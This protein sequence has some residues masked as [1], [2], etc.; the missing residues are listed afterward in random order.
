MT[1]ITDKLRLIM[2]GNNLLLEAEEDKY[3]LDKDNNTKSVGTD[4]TSAPA[5]TDDNTDDDTKSDDSDLADGDNSYDLDDDD[6][7]EGDADAPVTGDTVGDVDSSTDTGDQTS[8][9]LEGEVLNLTP[10]VRAILAFKNFD[11]YRELRDDV[12]GL[13]TELSEFVPINDE[14]RSLVNVTIEK[15]T[16]LLNKLNDYILYKYNDTS[17]EVNYYNYMQFI[18]EKRYLSQLYDNVLKSSSQAKGSK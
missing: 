13:I 18:L 14:I 5:T 16:D 2:E 7:S 1:K 12:S 17:F 10:K 6:D 11:H 3:N 8:Q 4:D 9:S 15:S